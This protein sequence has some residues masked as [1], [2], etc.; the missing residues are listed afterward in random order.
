MVCPKS[1]EN[2]FTTTPTGIGFKRW[3]YRFV[4]KILLYKMVYIPFKSEHYKIFYIKKC[5]PMF[6]TL[7]TAKKSSSSQTK[8]F[9]ISLTMNMQKVS[10][11]LS[12]W[13]L[14]KTWKKR[15]RNLGNL[16]SK[17]KRKFL[18]SV[19][20]LHVYDFL[21]HSSKIIV[22]FLNSQSNLILDSF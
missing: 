20:I 16:R 8:N 9:L 12:I 21:E 10:K 18:W 3:G 5:R 1:N 13:I 7:V 4:D 19:Q 11:A 22:H 2:E 6:C 14:C 17:Y 15:Y